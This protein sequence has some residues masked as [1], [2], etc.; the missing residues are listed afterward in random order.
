MHEQLK[1]IKD[2]LEKIKNDMGPVRFK[3]Q[4]RNLAY[5]LSA[6]AVQSAVESCSVAYRDLFDPALVRESLAAACVDLF[7]E[8]DRDLDM[9]DQDMINPDMTDQDM[10]DKSLNRVTQ[11]L[12][13]V[14]KQ[15]FETLLGSKA[16]KAETL[17][18]MYMLIHVHHLGL[19]DAPKLSTQDAFNML[20]LVTDLMAIM[21][22]G[23]DKT[24]AEVNDALVGFVLKVKKEITA[25]QRRS[26]ELN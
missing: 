6:A 3:E 15:K 17:L 23:K 5:R 11:Q 18:M 14:W 24:K 7:I 25:R 9:T 19:T 21:A 22:F 26:A 13:T 1:Q 2:K 4:Q 16:N 10:I 20:D 8:Y 12:V